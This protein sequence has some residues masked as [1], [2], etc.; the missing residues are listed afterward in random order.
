MSDVF[1]GIVRR[2]TAN[3][4]SA[5]EVEATTGF[6]LASEVLNKIGLF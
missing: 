2:V 1:R 3:T 4:V 5:R 6:D